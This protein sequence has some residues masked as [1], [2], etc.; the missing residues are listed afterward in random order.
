MNAWKPTLL[1]VL[2]ASAA[3]GAFAW[4]VT[5]TKYDAD[6]ATLN[7]DHADAMK[8]IS[9]KAA[10]DSEAARGREHNFQQRIAEL[11]ARYTKEQENAKQEAARLRADIISGQRRV[12]FASAA[13]ATCEQSAGAVRIASGLGDAA[14]IKLSATAGR[15]ILD[16]RSGITED[17]RKLAYLHQYIN[18]LQE[19]GMVANTTK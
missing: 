15:N 1:A 12:Q 9:D 2:V 19:Q 17:Q 13:L 10:A 8:T 4:W 16:I 18:E 11:D 3:G 5:S 6:I 7:S 14:S